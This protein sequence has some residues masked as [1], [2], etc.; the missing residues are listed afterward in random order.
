MMHQSMNDAHQ[1]RTLD[2]NSNVHHEKPSFASKSRDFKCGKAARKLKNIQNIF[3]T[4]AEMKELP[5]SAEQTQSITSSLKQPTQ[6]T[7]ATPQQMNLLK[8]RQLAQNQ[9]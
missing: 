4:S 3:W 7:Q 8:L 5:T 2:S 9:K 6:Q 1:Y